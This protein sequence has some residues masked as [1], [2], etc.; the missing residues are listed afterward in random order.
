MTLNQ[1]A[2]HEANLL[3][4]RCVCV[5]A[6]LVAALTLPGLMKLFGEGGTPKPL[7]MNGELKSSISLLRIIPVDFDL[8]LEPK[9]QGRNKK[10]NG[11]LKP[12]AVAGEKFRCSAQRAGRTGG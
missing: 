5:R 9:L 3:F 2:H 6:C 7:V 11:Y 10:N 4:D 8:T 12:E 1:P